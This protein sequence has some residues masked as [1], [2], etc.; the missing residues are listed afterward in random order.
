MSSFLFF[1]PNIVASDLTP[2]FSFFIY[3][4]SPVQVYWPDRE[5]ILEGTIRKVVR[6]VCEAHGIAFVPTPAL[7]LST[8]RCVCERGGS[9]DLILSHLFISGISY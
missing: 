6:R 9:S 7:P 4:N 2:Y 1:F 5:D 3:S 8:I